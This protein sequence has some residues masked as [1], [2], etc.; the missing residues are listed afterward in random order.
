MQ[1]LDDLAAGAPNLDLKKI[2]TDE[3]RMRVG[4]FRIVFARYTKEQ[5][6]TVTRIAD[7]KD[8]YR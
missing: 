5:L 2:G 6:I 8:V 7:R 1:R 3:Y 4:D